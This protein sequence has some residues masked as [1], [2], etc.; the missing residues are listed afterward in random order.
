[1]DLNKNIILSP[2]TSLLVIPGF[3]QILNRQYKKAGIIM[4]IV[5]LH[6]ILFIFGVI[7]LFHSTPEFTE[8]ISAGSMDLFSIFTQNGHFLKYVVI[9]ISLIWIYGFF[10]ALYYSI[11]FARSNRSEVIHH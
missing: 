9:S 7:D 8:K 1:M 3:G 11:K 2:L 10:D 5:F 6:I 4:A